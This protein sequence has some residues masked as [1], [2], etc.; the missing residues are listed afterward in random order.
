LEA[1]IAAVIAA[2]L[3][4]AT[5]ATAALVV[6]GANI[7]NGTIQLA[8]L[9]A[10]AKKAL[11]GQRG[12]RGPQGNAGP[13][14]PAGAAGVKGDRGALGATGPKGDKGDKGDEGDP[15]QPAF[16]TFGPVHIEGRDDYGS[17]TDGYE[18]WAHDDEDRYF[19]IEPTNDGKGYLVTRYDVNGTYTTIPGRQHPGCEDAG[20]FESEDTGKWNG[21]WARKVTS[22][23]PGFDYNPDAVM[24]ASGAWADVFTAFFGLAP[25]VDP[26]TI[27]YEFDYYN[28]CGDH[29]RD[30]YYDGASVG[31]GTIGDCP[32]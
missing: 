7:K 18:V 11:K 29:W 25:D 22:D 30:S 31:S 6:T 13:Q 17:A 12:R 20:T 10:K 19:T 16:G 2:V 5:G 32:S 27:S 9:S 3:I 26:P 24:P 23:M 1:V 15:G 14:G 21:V 4:T 28:S 8:D